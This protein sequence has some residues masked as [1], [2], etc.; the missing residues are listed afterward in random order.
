[1]TAHEGQFR[2][3]PDRYW[4]MFGVNDD[5]DPEVVGRDQASELSC[6]IARLCVPG[7]PGCAWARDRRSRWMG[8]TGLN[9]PP[10][11]P[12]QTGRRYFRMYLVIV[13]ARL[14]ARQRRGAA[15]S[16]LLVEA[17]RRLNGQEKRPNQQV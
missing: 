11:Q 8:W 10:S 5:D 1:M 7:V 3:A 17:T 12:Q 2:R 4:W 16:P 15:V 9:P 13:P 6:P 14:P